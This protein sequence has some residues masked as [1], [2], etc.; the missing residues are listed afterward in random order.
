MQFSSA[1]FFHPKSRV[2]TTS[3]LFCFLIYVEHIP[4]HKRWQEKSTVIQFA[5]FSSDE[6]PD[7]LSLHTGSTL[8]PKHPTKPKRTFLWTTGTTLLSIITVQGLMH[9]LG[10]K[11]QPERQGP[12][13]QLS[14]TPLI[15]IPGG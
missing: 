8:P 3:Q 7:M 2:T 9:C 6:V 14:L 12:F 10:F 13:C 15:C 5:Y 4:Q 1:C 11:H